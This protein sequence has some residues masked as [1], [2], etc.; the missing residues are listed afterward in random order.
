MPECQKRGKNEYGQSK[1]AFSDVGIYYVCLL[2]TLSIYILIYIILYMLHKV[3][4]TVLQVYV[5]V[6]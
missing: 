5:C 3:P 2:C 1:H 4:S 6:V